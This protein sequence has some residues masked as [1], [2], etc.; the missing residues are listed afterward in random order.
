MHG[1]FKETRPADS[2]FAD[3][4]VFVFYVE[5]GGVVTCF[6]DAAEEDGDVCNLAGGK[7]GV[8]LWEGNV[9]RVLEWMLVMV[10]VMEERTDGVS[11][12]N[13]L[14]DSLGYSCM[15][16]VCKPNMYRRDIGN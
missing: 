5:G 7:D 10:M 12:G 1:D 8:V 11:H 14:L 13:V 2:F 3:P 6:H 16:D 15:V 9:S 4:D